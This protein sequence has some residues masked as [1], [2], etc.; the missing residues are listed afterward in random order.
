MMGFA[1][2]LGGVFTPLTGRLGDVFGLESVLLYSAF[3]PLVTLVLI[4]KFPKNLT[5]R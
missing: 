5:A 2:G 1:Y 3:V 4:A